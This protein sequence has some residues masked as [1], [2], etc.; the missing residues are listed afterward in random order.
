MISLS[1]AW[2]MSTSVMWS[3]FLSVSFEDR[4]AD[5]SGEIDL[6]EV[7]LT[8]DPQTGEYEVILEADPR[9]GFQGSFLIGINLFNGDLETTELDPSYFHSDLEIA[10]QDCPSLRIKLSGFEPRLRAWSEGDRI[11][12]SGP[13]PLGL[14]S[15]FAI[16]STGLASLI[17][18][19]QGK[20]TVGDGEFVRLETV[21]AF[22]EFQTSPTALDDSFELPEDASTELLDVLKNDCSPSDSQ[23]ALS[24]ARI[25]NKVIQGRAEIVDG[26]IAYTPPPEFFGIEELQYVVRDSQG[27]EDSASVTI[28]VTSV[29][30][31]PIA[32]DDQIEISGREA[33][34]EVDVLQNDSTGPETNE[35]LSILSVESDDFSGSVT[36]EEG[37]LLIEPSPAFRDE[38]SIS[39]T[40]SD[41]NGGVASAIV[42]ITS[43]YSNHDP[44]AVEDRV[45]GMEDT[46]TII[47]VLRNDTVKPDEGETL[48]IASVGES[49]ANATLTMVNGKIHYLPPPDFYGV[50]AFDYRISDGF[51]GFGQASVR[52]NVENTNDPPTAVDDAFEMASN[53]RSVLF[54][55]L[56]NDHSDPDPPE[57][58]R[59]SK[60]QSTEEQVS[61]ALLGNVIRAEATRGFVGLVPFEYWIQDGNGGEA[62]GS[63]VVTVSDANSPPTANP[64]VIQI[65]PNGDVTTIDVL[66]NDSTE[67]DQE[68]VLSIISV[69]PDGI[70][71]SQV[72]HDGELVFFT[73]ADDFEK[74]WFHYIASDGNHGR[75]SA[76]VIVTAADV[77]DAPT[78]FDD[79]ITVLEDETSR[80]D[81]IGNDIIAS[82]FSESAS[83]RID[84]PMNGEAEVTDQ[85]VIEYRPTKDFFGKDSISYTLTYPNGKSSSAEISLTVENTNDKPLAVDDRFS[86]LED[87]GT[88]R[89][90]VL[91]NDSSGPDPEETLTIVP[92]TT[93]P[94]GRILGHFNQVI[95]YQPAEG[96][97]GTDTFSYAVRD[98]GGEIAV[99]R[100]DVIV[101]PTNDPPLARPDNVEITSIVEIT[102]IDVLENDS[103]APDVGEQLRVFDVSQGDFGG[104]VS[105]NNNQVTYRPPSRYIP[106]DQFTYSV[107]DGNGGV[108][109]GNVFVKIELVDREPIGQS[110]KFT[111]NEDTTR[112]R[113][114]VLANDQSGGATID[115]MELD[116]IEG[117]SGLGTIEVEPTA[118]F[119]SPQPNFVGT[120]TF[121]Y[122]IR[123]GKFESQPVSVEIEVLP[124]NDPPIATDESIT[125]VNPKTFIDIDV[126]A[127]D[128]TGVDKGEH[129]SI[130][131]TNSDSTSGS[132]SIVGDKIRYE[133]A[134][135]FV[136]IEQFTYSI[137]DGNGGSASGTVTVETLRP[138]IVP[139]TIKC[140]DLELVLPITGSLSLEA[141]DFDSGSS[142][143]SGDVTLTLRPNTFGIENIG[144]NEVVIQG[145][146]AS[147]NTSECIAKLTL[148]P[149]PQ[150]QIFIEI[151]Q[152]R[153]QSVFRVEEVYSFSAADIPIE[154]AFSEEIDTIEIIGDDRLLE[155]ISL[156]A[157][158]TSASW[159]WEEV[160]WGDHEIEIIGI[161]E[162]TGRRNSIQSRFSVNELASRAALILPIESTDSAITAA[163]E[164][165]FEMG[166]NVEV[167]TE[168]L[169]MNFL[170]LNWDLLIW[171][172]LESAQV[173][174]ESIEVFEEAANQGLSLYFLGTG[175]HDYQTMNADLIRRWNQLTLLDATG[176]NPDSGQVELSR[177]GGESLIAG[178]F[179]QVNDFS[180]SDVTGGTVT[181]TEAVALVELG[182]V[183]IAV[184]VE[185]PWA[186]KSPIGRRFTQ[187]FPAMTTEDQI[188][189]KSLFQNVVCWLLEDCV[190][191][192][193]ANL[194][195]T[196][197]QAPSNIILGQL[198]P[199][200]VL[201]ENNGACEITGAK[202]HLSA[203][204]LE[205]VQLLI[206]GRDVNPFFEADQNRWTAPV[207]RIGKGSQAV[208]SAQLFLKV[209]SPKF[210]NL[211][212]ETV[213]NT[214]K[215]LSIQLPVDVASF[216]ISPLPNEGIAINLT[217]QEGRRFEI[218]F[219][220]DLL[221]PIQWKNLFRLVEIEAQG[222]AEIT[223]ENQSN[224]RFYRIRNAEF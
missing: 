74:G 13:E 40:V 47:D 45:S 75:D 62:M 117:F 199:V 89:L 173:S 126:L 210:T 72:T 129:L 200:E 36:I 16:F 176:K 209:T 195:A 48:H 86:A 212:I 154:L 184:S 30:D 132:V 187:T 215:P 182:G 107:S 58:L 134:P 32:I 34:Y 206:D 90:H 163:R 84:Q 12:P 157:G 156:S 102:D 186:A 100:V 188:P 185:T 220:D 162:Q 168:P 27:V 87:G 167:F 6:R 180:L 25:E 123:E 190:D 49:H 98:E 213:S 164:Y 57:T 79:F 110:D 60:I 193:N 114:D 222:T 54:E 20:D 203:D 7:T 105:I 109:I 124:V 149:P 81:A 44:T 63:G 23:D 15:G 152:P 51:G 218:D 5:Q 88:I 135:S 78:A 140:H 143:D 113:L 76:L 137:T 121:N 92:P 133:P 1:V 136:G 111:V 106:E 85:L 148:S 101:R 52:V 99:A 56:A 95:L 9:A 33:S 29:N 80:L 50:D 160:I 153:P 219:T 38:A 97:S 201:L 127:N 2:L 55:P 145:V 207:G 189:M 169:P 125:L 46:L 3:Q 179:G 71:G 31:L 67:P 93:T 83:L 194:P 53:G 112:N 119:F 115:S 37:H 141:N 192:R 146:D 211:V 178:R 82:E 214:T 221:S 8:F 183:E 10:N 171:H 175:L 39:Y 116:R 26:F 120:L 181:S 144:I 96:F 42:T 28:V 35:I 61:L 19:T 155:I 69:T 166:V 91:A 41:G 18:P 216:S 223:L 202:V 172:G 24:I 205:V 43:I 122:R 208:R 22:P 4:A 128:S 17:D 138:D 70:P 151:L 196:V 94:H 131:S 217:G 14:P 159:I 198:F 77:G 118:L 165:L 73:P 147:G 170:E 158:E 177:G 204:G 197:P 104:A 65:N 11:A 64:D 66:A 224:A 21:S 68:E 191:C 130:E 103:I 108:A 174:L 142:D 161:D 139:P 150:S 59:L